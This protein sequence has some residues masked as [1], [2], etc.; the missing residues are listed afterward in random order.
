MTFDLSMPVKLIAH[1][2]VRETSGLAMSSRNGYLSQA[3]K[4]QAAFLYQMLTQVAEELRQGNRNI[5]QLENKAVHEINA[6]GF[7][8]DYVAIRNTRLA[9]V[10]ESGSIVILLAA[11]LGKTRLIDNLVIKL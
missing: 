11:Y 1:P 6:H 4:S 10:D 3:Q 7:Q 2:I 5:E 9:A 8:C